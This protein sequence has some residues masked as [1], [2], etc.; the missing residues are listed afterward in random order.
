MDDQ[1]KDSLAQARSPIAALKSDFRAMKANFEP[2][3]RRNIVSPRTREL[4]QHIRTETAAVRTRQKEEQSLRA[5]IT[6][7]ASEVGYPVAAI[8][9]F[10][11]STLE[12]LQGMRAANTTPEEK[13]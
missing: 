9:D 12:A 4:N 3:F 1:T 5:R 2:L 11:E 13:Q 6:R 7:I 8:E 10:N